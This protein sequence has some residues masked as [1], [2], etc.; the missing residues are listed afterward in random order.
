MPTAPPK[1]ADDLADG[2]YSLT[3]TESALLNEDLTV[4]RWAIGYWEVRN[5]AMGYQVID[6]IR[7]SEAAPWCTGPDMDEVT[8]QM[9][10][11]HQVP[12]II[13]ERMKEKELI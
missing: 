10:I 8:E 2:D 7:T 11:D 6:A 1:K 9:L 3:I 5:S 12:S 4:A 13:I